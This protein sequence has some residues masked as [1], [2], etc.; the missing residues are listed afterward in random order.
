MKT[1]LLVR[2]LAIA[3]KHRRNTVMAFARLWPEGDTGERIAPHLA[4]VTPTR[5]S[6]LDSPAK[7]YKLSRQRAWLP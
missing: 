3:S 5:K 1:N 6:A 4:A 7:V 2:H